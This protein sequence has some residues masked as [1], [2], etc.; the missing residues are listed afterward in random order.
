LPERSPFAEQAALDALRAC[1]YRQLGVSGSGAAV[2]VRVHR[3]RDV[4]APAEMPAH[5]LDLV[6]V[7]IRC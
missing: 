1:Q 4:L 5:P 2:V 7:D 3:K 6:G